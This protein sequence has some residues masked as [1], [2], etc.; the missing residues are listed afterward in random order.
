MASMA[1]LLYFYGLFISADSLKNRVLKLITENT[2]M[3]ILAKSLIRNSVRKKMQS[4][5]QFFSVD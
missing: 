5:V 1:S 3:T 4:N 2:N